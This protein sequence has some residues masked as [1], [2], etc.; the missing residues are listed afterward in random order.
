MG[1]DVRLEVQSCTDIGVSDNNRTCQSED[2]LTDIVSEKLVPELLEIASYPEVNLLLTPILS[3]MSIE[4]GATLNN[5][6]MI[7][8]H[9]DTLMTENNDISYK[10][11]YEKLKLML[12]KKPEDFQKQL[13]AFA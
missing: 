5:G 13:I 8:T 11:L 12:H 2:E 7:T 9:T 6:S 3:D 10:E 1:E 4:S